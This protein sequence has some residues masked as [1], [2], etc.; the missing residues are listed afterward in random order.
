MIYAEFKNYLFKLYKND[1]EDCKYEIEMFAKAHD[2]YR[3]E[4]ISEI[5]EQQI[6]INS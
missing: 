4:Q 6:P 3:A 5:L 2:H 1:L